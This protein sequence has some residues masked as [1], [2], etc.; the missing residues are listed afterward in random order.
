MICKHGGYSFYGNDLMKLSYWDV[1]CV[2]L[3]R[4][5]AIRHIATLQVLVEIHVLILLN[6]DG[7]MRIMSHECRGFMSC[8]DIKNI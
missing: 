2:N 5:N 4:E 1:F 3:N 6:K 8:L 7:A